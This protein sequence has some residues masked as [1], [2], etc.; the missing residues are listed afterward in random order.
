MAS[1]L[2]GRSPATAR[3]LGEEES[4]GF[5]LE[6]FGEEEE[7][8]QRRGEERKGVRGWIVISGEYRGF[9]AK[10]GQPMEDYC[11]LNSC[12]FYEQ[13]TCSLYIHF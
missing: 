9:T 3:Q 11:L 8:K 6:F 5:G 7:A 12:G 4:R 10:F 13:R 2:G 1:D